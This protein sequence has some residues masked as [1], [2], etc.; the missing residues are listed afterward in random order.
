MLATFHL[1]GDALEWHLWMHSTNP[2]TNWETFSRDIKNH[3][4]P[5]A[6]WNAEVALN[7]LVQTTSL[8]SYISEFVNLSTRT[9][10]LT[11]DNLLNRFLAGLR[12]D[13]QRELVLLQPKTLHEAISMARIAD[14]KITAYKT[15][16]QKQ[17]YVKTSPAY[18]TQPPNALP[19]PTT[20][21][22]TSKSPFPKTI[23]KLPVRQYTTAEIANR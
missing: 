17:P 15:W 3:F 19:P 8:S 7:K 22:L 2:V 14:D 18:S 21:Q 12:E 10:G 23:S 6:F 20:T 13:I 9:P 5:S 4:G 16:M 1:T 11:A